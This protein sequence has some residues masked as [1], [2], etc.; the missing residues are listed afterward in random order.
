LKPAV[1]CTTS[2]RLM[3]SESPAK[4][5]PAKPLSSGRKSKNPCPFVDALGELAA[6][7][8]ASGLLLH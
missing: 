5:L 8:Q 7:R 1:S 3:S 4:P 6:C 2:S